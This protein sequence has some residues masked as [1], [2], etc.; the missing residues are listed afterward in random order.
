MNDDPPLSELRRD[1]AAALIVIVAVTALA[2]AAHFA[3]W[4]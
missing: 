4:L 2:G 1:V 3:G